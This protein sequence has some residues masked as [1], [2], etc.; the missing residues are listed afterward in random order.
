VPV[1]LGVLL[2]V[3]WLRPLEAGSRGKIDGDRH[4]S[5]RQVT[6]LKT[7][8]RGIVRRDSVGPGPPTAAAL[9]AGVP[10]AVTNGRDGAVRS[11]GSRAILRPRATRR[12]NLQSESRRN[13]QSSTTPCS[14]SVPPPIAESAIPSDSTSDAGPKAVSLVVRAP[15]ESPEYPGRKFVV[16]CADI[17]RA[18][19]T[20]TRSDARMLAALAWR[21]TEVPR[22]VAHWRQDQWV[23]ISARYLAR[24][25]PWT[26]LPAACTWAGARRTPTAVPQLPTSLPRR[27]ASR[28]R[29]ASRKPCTAARRRPAPLSASPPPAWRPT[30]SG[31]KCHR[32]SP[33]C[34]GPSTRCIARPATCTGNTPPPKPIACGLGR[35]PVEVGFS[36]DLTIDPSLQAL[37]QRT[38]A[39]Y[40][41]RQDVCEALGIRRKED[42]GMA[43]G[44]RLLERAVVR[45]AAVAV[46]DV[47]TG[48]I[49]ALAGALS[50]CTRE[51]YDGP[52][53]SR[54]CDKRMPY[55]I[56]Y[57][58]DALLNAA[59]FHDAMPAS[60]IK[61][62]MATAF[63]ADPDVGPRWLASERAEM[64]RTAWPSRDSLRGQ[65]MRSGLGA[66][67]RSHVLRRPGIRQLPPAVASTGNR[68]GIRVECR[69]QRRAR[70]VRQARSSVR[71]RLR[72]RRRFRHP[73]GHDRPVRAAVGRARQRKGGCAVRARKAVPLDTGKVKTCARGLTA[74][75]ETRTTG[76]SA[77]AASSSTSSPTAGARAMRAR[78]R[79]ALRA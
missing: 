19:A 65:L 59:V 57:R 78:A 42:D 32:R 36:T 4:V 30:M 23:E 54:D 67:S 28:S 27:K 40:T 21:G 73:V 10:P 31:G 68:R 63:L 46:V 2:L 37:A 16:Q 35:T 62:I 15:A 5:V 74:G 41:G 29:C 43:V 11:R 64:Q 76:R 70:R 6:A 39:C 56:R 72:S 13:L 58:P 49:E 51:E 34:C 22:V 53:R 26:G 25:N 55:P 45:M 79:S 20:L 33:P 69:L 66:L 44:H 14:L 47:G 9:L 12:P 61:P 7:F 8:E 38:A 1:L 17:A 77:A 24:T 3:A 48:R 52:G 18:V 60:V 50:P 75:T 71:P